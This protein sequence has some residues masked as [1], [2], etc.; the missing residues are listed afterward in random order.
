MKFIILPVV[1]ITTLNIVFFNDYS[2][3]LLESNLSW[4]FSKA[5]PY[6]TLLIFGIYLAYWSKKNTKFSKSIGLLVQILLILTPFLVGFVLNPIYE[7]DFSKNGIEPKFS[8][9][10]EFENYDLVVL[11]I[12]GCPF[13]HESVINSNFML[14]RNPKLKIKY[15]LC[16]S[17]AKEME[18]YRI[19]LDKKIPLV[20]AKNLQEMG[21][22]AQ[23]KF[24]SF[25]LLNKNNAIYQWSNDGFGVRAKDYVES[26][27][28]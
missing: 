1:I 16:S 22:I 15:I 4:T 28:K 27:V 18:P 17:D 5:F 26:I 6:I 19:E 24:P 11:T 10:K 2:N 12:P 3:F 21:K 9:N 25:V 8:K 7:G 23:G 20:L 14:K 13:C